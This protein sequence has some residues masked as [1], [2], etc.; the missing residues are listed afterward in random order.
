M[1]LLSEG[2][3]RPVCPD[4]LDSS[5]SGFHTSFFSLLTPLQT[6]NVLA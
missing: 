4:T 2:K 5:F 6:L 3:L 1:Y